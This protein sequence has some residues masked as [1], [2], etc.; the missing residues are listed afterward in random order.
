MPIRTIPVADIEVPPELSR[1]RELSYNLWWSW[2][3]SARRFFSSI[4]Q[5]LWGI[6][7]NPV[8]LLINIEPHHWEHLLNNGAFMADYKN[9]L[10]EFDRYMDPARETEFKRQYPDY[11]NGPFAYFSTEYGLH[12]SLGIYCGGL[13]VLSGDH[14]KAASDMGL[15][16]VGIGI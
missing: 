9:L 14:A 3:P 15:P 11:D 13:G 1:L 2:N 6:Y 5:R 16:F 4:D 7:R 12:E 10:R 8:Q